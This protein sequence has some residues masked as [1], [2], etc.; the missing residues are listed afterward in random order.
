[1]V[2]L[3]S[4]F[5]RYSHLTFKDKVHIFIR[6]VTVP[7]DVILNNFPSGH[8]LID[9]GCGHGLFINLLSSWKSGFEKYIGVDADADKIGIARQTENDHI[10]FYH[11][12][13]F[14][15]EKSAD[16]YSFF[17]VLYL[18]PY[19]IQEKIIKHIFRKLPLLWWYSKG[20]G[21]EE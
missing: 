13:L 19:D 14:N 18:I 3:K 1:M 4:V 11:T 10:F 7:W 9:V 21:S 16:V 20:H 12:D 15:L 8:T 17:D 5:K 6:R 2:D